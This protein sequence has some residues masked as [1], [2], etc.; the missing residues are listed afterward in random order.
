LRGRGGRL[1][2][3]L[4]AEDTVG[5]RPGAIGHCW[6]LAI[7]A[8][9]AGLDPGRTQGKGRKG[10]HYLEQDV[11]QGCTVLTVSKGERVFF[12]GNDDYIPGLLLVVGWLVFQGPLL[13]LVTKKGY[14]PSS[15][16]CGR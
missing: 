15:T 3:C 14:G 11:P 2:S 6:A 10:I 8:K 9:G 16:S 5:W 12:G 4:G 13:T 7:T 1:P